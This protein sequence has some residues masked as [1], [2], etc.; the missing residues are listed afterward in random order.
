MGEVVNLGTVRTMLRMAQE[1]KDQPCRDCGC[2]D[3][4]DYDEGR[5][6]NTDCLCHNVCEY[7]NENSVYCDCPGPGGEE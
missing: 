2:V 3:P 1:L 5:C 4:L 6:R 7:C